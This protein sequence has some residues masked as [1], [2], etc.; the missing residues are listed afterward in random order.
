MSAIRII[1]RVTQTVGGPDVPDE[2]PPTTVSLTC[3]IALKSG[4]ARGRHSLKVRPEQPGG[5]QLPAI[6]LP[7]YFEGEERGHNVLLDL[8]I[9]AH[10]EGLYWIDVILNEVTLLTRIPLRVVYQPQRFGPPPPE[11]S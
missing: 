10:L 4:E 11:T 9:Q 3:L 5:I 7:V 6:D 8:S 2:M 1:D